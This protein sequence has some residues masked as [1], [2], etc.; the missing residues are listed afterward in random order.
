MGRNAV[1]GA[2]GAIQH[3][4]KFIKG[5]IFGK[6]VFEKNDISPL[7][8]IDSG[9]FAPPPFHACKQKYVMTKSLHLVII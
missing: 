4:M 1:S 2:V 6:S 5:I 8:V 7:C 3:Y 9:G